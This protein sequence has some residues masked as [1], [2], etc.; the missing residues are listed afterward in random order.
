MTKMR[1]SLAIA[2]LLTFF[3]AMLLSP[4]P[5][6]AAVDCVKNPSHPKCADGGGGGGPSSNIPVT[7]EFRSSTDMDLVECFDEFGDPIYQICSDGHA[8]SSIY[9]DGELNV[10]AAIQGKDGL[11]NLLFS[12]PKPAKKLPPKRPSSS[13]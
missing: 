7:V 9:R 11:G 12:T 5:A 4:E 10:Q 13:T 8:P 6:Q 3:G 2:L 1:A